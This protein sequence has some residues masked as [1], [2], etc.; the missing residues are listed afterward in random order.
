MFKPHPLTDLTSIAVNV[1]YWFIAASIAELASAHP[2]AGGVYYWA[3]ITGGPRYGRA[4]GFFAGYWNC[5]AWI[6]GLATICNIASNIAVQMWAIYHPDFVPQRWHVLVGY[7]IVTWCC[8]CIVLFANRA[9]PAINNAGGF[10]VIAGVLITIVV[11]AV[12]P[13]KGGGGGYASNEF[14]WRDWSADLGY[15]SK[16]FIFLMGTANGAYAVGTPDAVTHVA[17]EIPR[18]EI[19]VPKA[20]GIQMAIAFLTSLFYLIAIFYS[21]TDLS[22]LSSG[23]AAF[24]LAVI[25]HQATGSAAGTIG[26]LLV[27]LLP[28]VCCTM[29]AYIVA[30]RMLWSLARD[31]ATPFSNTLGRV[32]TTWRNPF[33]A[34]LTC[35][36]IVTLLGCLYV[37]SSTAFNAFVGS[38]VIF[39]TCSYLAA[40]L[41]HILSRR[42][43]IIPGPFF[44][45]GLV[46][47]IVHGVSCSCIITVV[48][49]YCFPYSLPVSALS[50]NYA[51][52][53]TGGLTIFVAAWW[54]WVGKR[55]YKGPPILE[56]HGV[57]VDAVDQVGKAGNV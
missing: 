47:Y 33:N 24:P 38:F 48:I 19:N 30:G 39:S 36:L 49:I 13:G 26:L 32:S 7:L 6:V 12:M 45:P 9:L 43:N 56:I 3:T 27:I 52:L 2:N 57:A 20:I 37:G 23:S 5:F 34:T 14:V 28:V 15:S 42:A 11:C 31:G 51:S 17:E 8:C 25:Y 53:I 1:F 46:G 29:S 21:I 44:M 40:L 22:A 10:F 18:P 50:M 16:G 35:G 55:G 4:C 41:P 54:F